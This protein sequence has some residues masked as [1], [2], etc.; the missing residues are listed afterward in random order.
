MYFVCKLCIT[1]EIKSLDT[2]TP[3]KDIG[4]VLFYKENIAKLQNIVNFKAIG[5]MVI[6]P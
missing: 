5:H 1:N 2:N 4:L 6:L 3:F